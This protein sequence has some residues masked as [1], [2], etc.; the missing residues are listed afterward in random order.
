MLGTCTTRD[1]SL[2]SSFGP[3][4]ES[5]GTVELSPAPSWGCSWET[6]SAAG[7]ALQKGFIGILFPCPSVLLHKA[8]VA[9]AG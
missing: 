3:S 1:S 7:F 2:G 8:G 9:L 5:L 4:L 6:R